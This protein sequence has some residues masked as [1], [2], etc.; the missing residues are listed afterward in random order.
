[1]KRSAKIFLIGMYLHLILSIAVPAGILYFSDG[2]WN[3]IGIGLLVFYLLMIAA[4]QITGWVC[5]AMGV[6]ACRRNKAAELRQSWKLLKLWSIPFY[7]L[8]FIYSYL[9]WFVLVGAS[10]G[11]LLIL[12]PIPIML[13]CLMVVQSG[14]VGVCYILL[15]RKRDGY[16]PSGIHYVLQLLSVV[17]VISTIILLK[18]SKEDIP[19]KTEISKY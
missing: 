10:R 8:N 5:V 16:R 17:D 4:V 6:I 9:A 1:M 19:Q 11:I 2:G 12:V 13:T 15:L 7:V 3:G 18:S 14:C